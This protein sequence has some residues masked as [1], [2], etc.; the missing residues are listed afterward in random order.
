MNKG[1]WNLQQYLSCKLF[2]FKV[3]QCLDVRFNKRIGENLC[4]IITVSTSF[5][6]Q[7]DMGYA[8]IEGIKDA[9]NKIVCHENH[10]KKKTEKKQK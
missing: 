7:K 5:H 1:F 9:Y 2:T 8:K 4:S 6:I 10:D 3:F